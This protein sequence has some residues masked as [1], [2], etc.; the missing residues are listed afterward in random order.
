[1]A[2]SLTLH[3][4]TASQ[5]RNPSTN[6]DPTHFFFFTTFTSEI[7]KREIASHDLSPSS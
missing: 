2:S 5:N 3:Q 4:S 6:P 7:R 1:M